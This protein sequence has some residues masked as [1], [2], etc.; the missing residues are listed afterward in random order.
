MHHLVVV[1]VEVVD[2]TLKLVVVVVDRILQL[3]QRHSF[4]T[5]LYKGTRRIERIIKIKKF[6][7]IKN[8]SL[9]KEVE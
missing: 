1:V 6:I 5:F 2:Q 7:C 9:E 4:Q 3:I 8:A